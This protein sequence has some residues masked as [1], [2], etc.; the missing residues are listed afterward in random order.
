MKKREKKL[1]LHRETVQRLSPAELSKAHGGGLVAPEA[2][3]GRW[4]S[5]IEPNCC[6]T[7]GQDTL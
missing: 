4:T 2:E 7:V 1:H 5:C 6:G 3:T